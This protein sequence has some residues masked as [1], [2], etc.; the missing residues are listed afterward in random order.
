MQ[1]N[2]LRTFG[3]A[4]FEQAGSAADDS[5]APGSVKIRDPLDSQAPGARCLKPQGVEA[6]VRR[7]RAQAPSSAQHAQKIQKARVA[8]R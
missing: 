3:R 2:S 5:V 4:R 8:V 7:L 1:I 6:A